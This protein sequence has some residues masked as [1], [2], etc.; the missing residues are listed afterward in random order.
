MKLL[1][2]RLYRTSSKS[3]LILTQLLLEVGIGMML[4][5]IHAEK[6]S[7]KHNT[8]LQFHHSQ[9]QE[10]YLYHIYDLFKDYCG[11]V[12]FNTSFY[13]T[14]PNRMK[15][16]LSVKFNTLSIPCFNIFRE[17]FYNSSGVKC[18]PSNLGEYF[19]ARSLAY[20]FMDD[21][22]KA[23]NGYYFCTES[24]SENDINL[25]LA[26]LRTKFNLICSVHK[27]TNGP[28]IYIN[29]KSIDGFNKLVGPFILEGFKYKLHD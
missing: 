7:A 22:Y 13:D 24:F 16:Y 4:G 3:H 23:L 28:R 1:F 5:D 15:L 2:I 21:G 17:L 11:A 18:I 10:F 9:V 27:T 6:P 19:T 20:W 29:K 8:R 12:P 14:R 25:L 26:L